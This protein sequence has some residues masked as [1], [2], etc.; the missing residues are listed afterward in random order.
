[1]KNNK[2]FF[3]FI[4]LTFAL[5]IFPFEN[6]INR[7]TYFTHNLDFDSNNLMSWRY[8]KYKGLMPMVDFWYPYSGLYYFLSEFPPDIYYRWIGRLSILSLSVYSL[9]IIY[10]GSKVRVL[11]SLFIVFWMI[12]SGLISANDRYFYGVAFILLICSTFTNV[13][14]RKILILLFYTL[15][16]LVIEPAQ[17]IYYEFALSIYII[18]WLCKGL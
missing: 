14:Y 12:F 5:F 8:F 10:K 4:I 17:L 16:L 15:E 18:I 11:L 9:L 6:I 7:E 13:T 3:I 1:M 2:Y